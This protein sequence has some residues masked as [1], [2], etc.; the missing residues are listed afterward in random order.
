MQ[1]YARDMD[2]FRQSLVD[3]SILHTSLHVALTLTKQRTSISPVEFQFCKYF[4]VDI[5][6]PIDYTSPINP[7]E[8]TSY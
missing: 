5:Q 8:D 6:Y 1:I 3:F 2:D 7:I 4:T